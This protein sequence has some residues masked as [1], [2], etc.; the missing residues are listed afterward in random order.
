TRNGGKFAFAGGKIT[1]QIFAG[2]GTNPTPH[3]EMLVQT[4]A[5][6]FPNASAWPLPTYDPTYFN[7]NQ[8]IDG[9]YSHIFNATD[10]VRSVQ[11]DPSGP[12]KG[13]LR[14]VLEN[15]NVPANYYAPFPGSTSPSAPGYSDPNASSV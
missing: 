2:Y 10:T 9:T 13:D 15:P 7:F 4:I 6:S 8:R 1:I 3:P 11:V 12:T 14:M 5:L